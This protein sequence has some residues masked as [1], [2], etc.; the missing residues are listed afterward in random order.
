[1]LLKKQKHC[2]SKDVLLLQ[3]IE[4]DIESAAAPI[5]EQG[6]SIE[7]QLAEAKQR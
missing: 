4:K 6:Q 2:Y 3:E 5:L 7:A 1:V